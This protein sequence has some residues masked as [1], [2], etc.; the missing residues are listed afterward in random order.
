MP[1]AENLCSVINKIDDLKITN[2]LNI[3]SENIFE[4]NMQNEED[5]SVA[6][7]NKCEE[8]A[9]FSAENS[10]LIGIK[11]VQD[12]TNENETPS[13]KC[14]DNDSIKHCNDENSY[15]SNA[16]LCIQKTEFQASLGPHEALYP[17]KQFSKVN[18]LISIDERSESSLETK[19]NDF[20]HH[21]Y[22]NGCT[23]SIPS[24]EEVS[25]KIFRENWL[26]KIEVLRHREAI[27]RER[28]TN[29]QSRERELFRKEKELRIME[30][31]LNDKM[32][33]LDQQ[34]KHQKDMLV[35]E[36]RLEAAARILSDDIE[37]S[38]NLA[39]EKNL[40]KE[41]IPMKENI[42]KKEDI[43]KKEE[44]SKI[45][46]IPKISQ[47]IINP[48]ERSEEF[49]KKIVHPMRSNSSRRSFSSKTRSHATV[50][51]KE[52]RCK[53][54]YDDLNSTLSAASVDSSFMRTSELFNPALYKKPQVFTRSA[55]ERWIRPKDTTGKAQRIVEKT[56]EHVI[57][58]EKIFRKVSDNIC[59][60]QERETKFQNYGLVDYIPNSI[61]GKTEYNSGSERK[62]S[63]YLDLEIGEK[64]SHRSRASTSK[65]RPVSWTDETNERLQKKRHVYNS[66][67]KQ[68]TENK[69]NI[70]CNTRYIEAIRAKPKPKKFSLFG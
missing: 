24:P 44:I 5:A 30:R 19:L 65:N 67:T 8:F 29:L 45:V 61:L 4:K 7:H 53:I 54:N 42:P 49:H 50:K 34:A 56:S 47:P 20:C 28:E 21:G 16:R 6:S 32:K 60:L 23:A 35:V 10:K 62:L 11:I 1:E 41:D 38:D 58:E 57:E 18:S 52:R 36:K 68:S 15:R 17:A 2:Q 27:L 33:L 66:V 64:H 13:D 63:S 31:T 55:S 12:V 40:K 14:S 37:K 3:K 59:A 51:Y 46:E 39:E 22:K 26:Q 9:K 43:L 69:E 48:C 25:E 70:P